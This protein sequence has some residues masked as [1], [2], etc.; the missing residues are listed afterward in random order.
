M[1]NV[2]LV[3]GLYASECMACAP[4]CMESKKPTKQNNYEAAIK[5]LEERKPGT[6]R[7]Y[8]SGY[9]FSHVVVTKIENN[10]ELSEYE[11]SILSEFE[12]YFSNRDIGAKEYKKFVYNKELL[13]NEELENFIILI[14]KEADRKGE[15]WWKVMESR[16]FRGNHTSTQQHDDYMD[17][18]EYEIDSHMLYEAPET[19]EDRYEQRVREGLE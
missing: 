13:T 5:R 6:D 11:L 7:G 14:D 2:T 10:E 19:D 8:I 1:T 18:N 4:N 12:S 3:V 15:G 16:Y 17:I 9:E